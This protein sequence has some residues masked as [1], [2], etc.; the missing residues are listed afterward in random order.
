MKVCTTC[1]ISKKA[2]ADNFTKMKNGK[3]GVSSKCKECNKVYRQLNK[4]RL[5]KQKKEYYLRNKEKIDEANKKWAKNN[6]E[7]AKEYK[8]EWYQ[9]NKETKIRAYKERNKE[10]IS[11]AKKEYNE[12]HKAEKS[13]YWQQYYNWHKERIREQKRLYNRLNKEKCIRYTQKRVAL[14]RKLPASYTEAQWEQTKKFFDCKCAYC[15]KEKKLAQDHFIPL[16]SGGEYTINNIVPACKSCNSSKHNKDFFEWYPTFRYHS[17]Q[18]EQKIL[19]YL[20]YKD[21]TQQLSI[22]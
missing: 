13:A 6:A 3:Y 22:L 9:Q 20:N 14:K 10:H 19:K 15:G 16:S 4:D 11:N 12:K 21:K 1:G 18:R 2:T 5:N 17:K 7:R 8:A